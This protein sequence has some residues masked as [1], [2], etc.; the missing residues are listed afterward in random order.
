[1]PFDTFSPDLI[2]F[3][4]TLRTRKWFGKQKDR[5]EAVYKFATTPDLVSRALAEFA[6]LTPLGD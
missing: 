2:T 5:Y 1:M 3:L 4:T 6:R